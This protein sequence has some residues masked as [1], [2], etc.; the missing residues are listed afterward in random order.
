MTVTKVDLLDVK[1]T[2][3]LFG[4]RAA[5]VESV[6]AE[7]AETLGQAAEENRRLVEK[8][9]D[10]EKAVESMESREAA[11]R[12]TLAATQKVVEDLKENAR[13]QARL[14]IEDAK[15]KA[16]Q[17]I[18]EANDSVAGIK[19][20]V[21]DLKHRRIEFEMG[22]RALL[23]SHL[24]YLDLSEQEQAQAALGHTLS[25]GTGEEPGEAHYRQEPD[26]PEASAEPVEPAWPDEPDESAG[27]AG[28]AGPDGRD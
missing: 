13:E 27:L 8:I 16:A 17:V 9:R 5:E 28:L 26:Q 11:L 15:V 18:R 19:R 20:E 4:L 22:F 25:L 2:K 3:S 12:T 1:F 6:L 21:L 23:D 10:M 7:A 14:I 24:R